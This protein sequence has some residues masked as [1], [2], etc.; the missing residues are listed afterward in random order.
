LSI[1]KDKDMEEEPNR[2]F[3]AT[4]A[5]ER[6]VALWVLMITASTTTAPTVVST[7]TASTG[8]LP[9]ASISVLASIVTARAIAIWVGEIVI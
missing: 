7:T 1:K 3:V 4:V 6:I 5:K 9:F 8:V 2:D